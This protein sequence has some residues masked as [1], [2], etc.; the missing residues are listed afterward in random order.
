MR[1]KLGK[2]WCLAALA[3]AMACAA[4]I[5]LNNSVCDAA[6]PG[7]GLVQSPVPG[8]LPPDVKYMYQG[9]SVFGPARVQIFAPP[10]FQLW[11][12]RGEVKVSMDNTAVKVVDSS[13]NAQ[14]E[15][16]VQTGSEVYVG[17][18]DL[19]LLIIVLGKSKE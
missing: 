15:S 7:A 17:R 5:V 18:K 6:P 1:S 4:L 8:A 11:G 3:A 14:S 19:Q 10:D 12:A 16:N 9:Y 2:P 13:G